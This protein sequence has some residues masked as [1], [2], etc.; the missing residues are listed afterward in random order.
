MAWTEVKAVTLSPQM[1]LQLIKNP[2]T[3][4][5]WIQNLPRPGTAAP[6]VHKFPFLLSR[7]MACEWLQ[8]LTG[9]HMDF[10]WVCAPA[11]LMDFWKSLLWPRAEAALAEKQSMLCDPPAWTCIQLQAASREKDKSC[12]DNSSQTSSISGFCP[13]CVTACST[14]SIMIPI[15]CIKAIALWDPKQSYRCQHKKQLPSLFPLLLKLMS[16]FRSQKQKPPKPSCYS[17]VKG[18]CLKPEDSAK[19]E[20]AWQ[21][22]QVV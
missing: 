2:Q 8:S 16:M 17:F 3:N 13:R 11:L 4:K 9:T 5:I 6:T 18:P 19:F 10:L 20:D 22:H 21:T 1:L 12:T 7:A 14:W 15:C